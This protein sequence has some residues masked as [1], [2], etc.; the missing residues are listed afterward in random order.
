M[1]SRGRRTRT[2][3]AADWSGDYDAVEQLH[4]WN[5]SRYWSLSFTDAH[6][7]IQ[8]RD[9][10]LNC[11]IKASLSKKLDA[12][13]TFILIVGN[14]TKTVRSGSC[15]YCKNYKTYTYTCARGYSVDYRSYI[16]YECEKAVRDGLRIIVLYNAATVNKT[17]CRILLRILESMLP[18]VITKM[19]SIIGTIKRLKCYWI[20]IDR[21]G[22]RKCRL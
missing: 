14:S 22:K 8:A 3:I 20:N 21:L 9:N 6:D 12:S 17:K 2:Y 7:L 19:V 15:Q 18:C 13:K 1:T 5:S 16:E 11:S 4:K 10:S